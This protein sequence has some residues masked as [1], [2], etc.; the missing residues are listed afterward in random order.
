MLHILW[1]I[2]VGFFI[3]LIAR[4]IMPGA[5]HMGFIATSLVGIGGSLVGG[6]IARLF[7]KPKEGQPFH[8]AGIIM[9]II[10]A[11]ILLFVLE[12]LQ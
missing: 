12:K 7:S 9:S 2:I 4:A 5:G 6:F 10:G 11:M 3:G 1:S 8:P